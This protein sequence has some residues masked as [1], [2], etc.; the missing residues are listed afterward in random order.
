MTDFPPNS[1]SS[2][3]NWEENKFW[4]PLL[5]SF[6]LLKILPFPPPC[7]CSTLSPNSL[8]ISPHQI[9]ASSAGLARDNCI[10]LLDSERK[11]F[12]SQSNIA[13][14]ISGGFDVLGQIAIIVALKFCFKDNYTL[15]CA[16][17]LYS[18]PEKGQ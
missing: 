9:M 3:L 5:I 14:M 4:W 10:R 15:L 1:D 16:Y 7:L 18:N 8:Y 11:I 2:R 12:K 17:S 13:K 6:F